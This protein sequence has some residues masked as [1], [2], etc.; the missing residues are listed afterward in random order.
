MLFVPDGGAPVNVSDVPDTE[1]AVIGSCCTFS[2]KTSR[3]TSF[4]TDLVNVNTVVEPLPENLSASLG[5]AIVL[6]G[7]YMVEFVPR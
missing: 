7:S 5:E 2:T 3:S 4:W 6:V 1:K